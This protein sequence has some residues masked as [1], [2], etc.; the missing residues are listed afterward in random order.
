MSK[1]LYDLK[2]TTT[3]EKLGGQWM[4]CVTAT[5][6][7]LRVVDP[8]PG[9]TRLVPVD[10]PAS[11]VARMIPDLAL[12]SALDPKGLVKMETDAVTDEAMRV[13]VR[14]GPREN[15]TMSLNR[16]AAAMVVPEPPV[17]GANYWK[18]MKEL[19]RQHETWQLGALDEI[20][21]WTRCP[22]CLEPDSAAPGSLCPSCLEKWPGDGT[23]SK[24]KKTADAA[25]ATTIAAASCKDLGD[26]VREALGP[27]PECGGTGEVVLFTSVVPCSRGCRRCVSE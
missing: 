6:R 10:E 22:V 18:L 5:V 23:K 2:V 19:K 9:G 7:R 1:I 20:P 11:Q 4:V 21:T 17:R 8:G 13:A 16:V 26:V 15:L 24:K 3:E 14:R 12:T 27:C 25:P